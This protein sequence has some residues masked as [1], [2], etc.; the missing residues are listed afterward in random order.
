M[1]RNDF[2]SINYTDKDGIDY[3]IAV[4]RKKANKRTQINCKNN[5]VVWKQMYPLGTCSNNSTEEVICQPSTF[6]E[7]GKLCILVISGK[8]DMIVGLEEG[9]FLSAKSLENADLNK[10]YVMSEQAFSQLKF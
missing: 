4:T 10:M 2:I 9:I 3:K 5:H 6:I 8:P 7:P 1:E